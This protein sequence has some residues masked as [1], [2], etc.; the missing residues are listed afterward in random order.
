MV[1]V[2]SAMAAGEITPDEAAT[3]SSILEA[4]DLHRAVEL[5]LKASLRPS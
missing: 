5:I 3:I 1:A 2:M 4:G